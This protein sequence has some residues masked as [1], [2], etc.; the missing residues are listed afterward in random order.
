MK[1]IILVSALVCVAL[2]AFADWGLYDSDRSWLAID[3]GSETWYSLWNEGT[4]TFNGQDLGDFETTDTL[5]ITAFD[6]KT[7]KNGDSNVTGIEYFYTVYTGTRDNPSFTSMGGGWLEDL[8]GGNQK[9]GASS[10]SFDL[11][12][13]TS[14]GNT[15]TVE[16]YGHIT[17]TPGSG[18]GGTDQ[19]DNNDGDIDN[20]SATFDVIPEPSTMLMTGAVFSLAVLLRRFFRR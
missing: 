2:T 6:V 14:A 19:Y 4:G 3:D 9:W 15:Y 11:L 18:T 12:D 7:W 20:Y 1:R 13:G 5:D 17:G 10:L 8:G 16:V